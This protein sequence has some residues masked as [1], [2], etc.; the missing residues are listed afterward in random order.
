MRNSF[1]NATETINAQTRTLSEKLMLLG[2]CSAQIRACSV[3]A[4]EIYYE[5]RLA[6]FA[7]MLDRDSDNAL[8]CQSTSLLAHAS[9]KEC[10]RYSADYLGVARQCTAAI[11]IINKTI[12]EVISALRMDSERTSSVNLLSPARAAT[13]IGNAILAL[14]GLKFE[15]RK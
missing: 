7:A 9:A 12:V 5:A 4:T 8:K 13:E 1:S 11:S 15:T 2:E 6:S 3:S 10:E 14:E